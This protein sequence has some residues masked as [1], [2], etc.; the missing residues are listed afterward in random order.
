MTYQ[1]CCVIDA[2]KVAQV[3]VDELKRKIEK[4]KLKPKLIGFLA[5]N[6]LSAGNTK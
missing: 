2:A 3:F 4:N 6:D 5:N 1:E